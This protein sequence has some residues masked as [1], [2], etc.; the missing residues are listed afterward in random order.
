MVHCS[1]MEWR[2][3]RPGISRPDDIRRQVGPTLPPYDFRHNCL[4]LLCES[5]LDPL[6]AM[7]IDGQS[8]D[9]TI[10]NIYTYL[11]QETQRTALRSKLMVITRFTPQ[12]QTA[13]LPS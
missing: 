8:D 7:K 13:W 1:F 11:K 10:A 12:R 2:E 9:Q 3:V 5:G 6:I 4:T